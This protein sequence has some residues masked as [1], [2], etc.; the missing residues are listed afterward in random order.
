MV[1]CDKPV[2]DLQQLHHLIIDTILKFTSL[3][4][5]KASDSH[6]H[7][8]LYNSEQYVTCHVNFV[9]LKVPSI[10][11]MLSVTEMLVQVV[12]YLE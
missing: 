1:A 8:D 3:V 9:Q 6:P 11:V 4:W 7:E 10:A 2:L 5:A 12:L